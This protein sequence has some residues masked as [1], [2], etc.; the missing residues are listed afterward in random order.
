MTEP[1]DTPLTKAE[2]SLLADKLFSQTK[3]QFFDTLEQFGE[4][5]WPVERIVAWTLSYYDLCLSPTLIAAVQAIEE[6][7]EA[8]AAE[9]EPEAASSSGRSTA[10]SPTLVAPYGTDPYQAVAEGSKKGDGK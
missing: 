3:D 2:W 6:E 1:T 4:L 8:E 9:E 7:D 10:F 5:N